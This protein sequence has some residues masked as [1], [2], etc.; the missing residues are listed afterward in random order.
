M[1]DKRSFDYLKLLWRESGPAKLPGGGPQADR[2]TLDNKRDRT[3]H[4]TNLRTTTESFVESHR[5]NSEIR[6][7]E[8]LPELTAGIPLLL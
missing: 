8:N 6:K 1:A 4:S 3:T 2:R 5:K 7:L